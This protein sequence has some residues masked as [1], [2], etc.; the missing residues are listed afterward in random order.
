MGLCRLIHLDSASD[1]P[2]G[3]PF[4]SM[5]TPTIPSLHHRSTSPVDTLLGADRTGY[6]HPHLPPTGVPRRGEHLHSNFAAPPYARPWG[7]YSPHIRWCD[8]NEWVRDSGT[9]L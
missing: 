6:L 9:C 8:A 7:L 4:D 5:A 2:N 1:L 3:E